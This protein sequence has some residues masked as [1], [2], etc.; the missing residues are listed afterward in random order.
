[1]VLTVCKIVELTKLVTLETILVILEMILVTL[2]TIVVIG[3]PA[4]WGEDPTPSADPARPLG[5][6]FRG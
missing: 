3:L 5:D 4:R 6:A 1:L 2:E